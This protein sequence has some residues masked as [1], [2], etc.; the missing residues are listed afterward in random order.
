M[1]RHD[2]TNTEAMIVAEIRRAV[3]NRR[4]PATYVIRVVDGII[5]FMV[6]EPMTIRPFEGDICHVDPPN[7][8]R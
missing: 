1:S 3:A 6:A 7:G 8:H 5:Q 4:R 2:L